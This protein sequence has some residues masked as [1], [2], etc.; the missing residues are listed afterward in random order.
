M[1]FKHML[2]ICYSDYPGFY[3]SYIL[4]PS[5]WRIPRNILG[6]RKCL[7]LTPATTLDT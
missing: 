6:T 4:G 3:V 5:L 2:F 7:R 1:L